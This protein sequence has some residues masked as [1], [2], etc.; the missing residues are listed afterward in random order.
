ML[1]LLIKRMPVVIYL[2]RII[3]IGAIEFNIYLCAKPETC[4]LLKTICQSQA[5]G[6]DLTADGVSSGKC[7]YTCICVRLP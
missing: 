7:L 4:L 2:L 5:Y 3:S 6:L 1:L